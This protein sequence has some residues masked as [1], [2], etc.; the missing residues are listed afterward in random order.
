[1]LQLALPVA[2][3][4]P[5][6]DCEPIEMVMVRPWMGVTASSRSVAEKV[7]ECPVAITV[8]LV[9]A[10]LVVVSSLLMVKGAE[11]ELDA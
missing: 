4:G 9:T 11:A 8:G 3:V 7:V 6:H 10:N 1:M 5:T 2:S